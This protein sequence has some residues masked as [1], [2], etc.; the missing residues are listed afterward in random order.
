MVD[1]IVGYYILNNGPYA[2]FLPGI[3]TNS[4]VKC[5]KCSGNLNIYEQ[6]FLNQY[7]NKSI[8]CNTPI[9]PHT[10]VPGTLPFWVFRKTW[11]ENIDV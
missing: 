7:L 2:M 5:P 9:H 3:R 8:A 11:G 10:E 6:N 4:L 1:S